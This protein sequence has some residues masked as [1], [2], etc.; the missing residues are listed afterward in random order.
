MLVVYG[1]PNE[2][3]ELAFVDAGEATVSEGDGVEIGTKDGA[4]I[5]NWKTSSSRRVVQLGCGIHVYILGELW[6][7]AGGSGG[8]VH[9][10]TCAFQTET[11]P[12]TIGA[13]SYRTSVVSSHQTY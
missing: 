3:H 11:Q 12:T 2:H 6:I 8:V 4:T 13:S 10:L 9:L 1:G 5:L 7:A